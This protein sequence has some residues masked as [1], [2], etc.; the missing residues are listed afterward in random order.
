MESENTFSSEMHQDNAPLAQPDNTAREIVNMRIIGNDGDNY[1]LV[2]LHGTIVSFQCNPGYIPCGFKNYTTLLVVLA[3]NPVIDRSEIGIADINSVTK[4]GEYSP[5]YV[6][7]DLNFDLDHMVEVRGIRETLNEF[8]IYF[9]DNKNRMKTFNVLD[10]R[11]FPNPAYAPLPATPLSIGVQYMVVQGTI[12]HNAINYGPNETDN[13]FTASSTG[14]SVPAGTAKLIEYVP[15]E[16]FSIVPKVGFEMPRLIRRIDGSLTCG[17]YYYFYRL[18]DNRSNGTGYSMPSPPVYINNAE[19][20]SLGDAHQ[21]D[22]NM[23]GGEQDVQSLWGA[24]MQIDYVDENYT[25][26]ELVFMKAIDENTFEDPVIF[27]IIDIT[28]P[29]AT[30]DHTTNVGQAIP[31]NDLILYQL[32]I[33]KNKTGDINKNTLVIG[34]FEL[35]TDPDYDISVGA[36]FTEYAIRIP[37]DE[38]EVITGD[39]PTGSAFLDTPLYGVY[40]TPLLGAPQNQP[41]GGAGFLSSWYEIEETS[42]PGTGSIILQNSLLGTFSTPFVGSQYFQWPVGYDQWALNTGGANVYP[43][44]KINLYGSEARYIR[45]ENDYFSSSG[46]LVNHYVRS[47]W[48]GETYRIGLITTDLFGNPGYVHHI[49]DIQLQPHEISNMCSTFD[50]SNSVGPDR[51]YRSILNNIVI[52]VDQIDFN[53][54]VDA[55]KESQNDPS[56]TLANLPDFFTGFSIVLCKRDKVIHAEGL[57]SPIVYSATLGPIYSICPT[58]NPSF[59]RL[60]DVQGVR[61]LNRFFLRSPDLMF[62]I[63]DVPIEFEDGDLLEILDYLDMHNPALAYR[64]SPLMVSHPTFYY[65]KQYNSVVASTDQ[66]GLKNNIEVEGSKIFYGAGEIEIFGN[67][68]SPISY[69]ARI[70]DGPNAED[71]LNIGGFFPFLSCTKNHGAVLFTKDDA[72]GSGYFGYTEI[73]QTNPAVNTQ[74]PVLV[75]YKKRKNILYGGTGELAKSKNEYFFAGHYQR[76]DATFMAYLNSNAGIVEDI[77]LAGLDCHLELWDYVY[78]YPESYSSPGGLG[79]GIIMPIQSNA[80]IR[81]REGRNFAHESA[82]VGPTHLDGVS[83][84]A[85]GGGVPFQ[86]EQLVSNR[87]Y[88][89]TNAW[90]VPLVATPYGYKPRRFYEKTFAFSLRKTDGEVRDNLRRFIP[91]NTK[92][93]D[94]QYGAITNLKTKNGYLTFLQENAFGYIPI[95]ERVTIANAVGQ[96][97]NIGTKDTIDEYQTTQTFYGSRN[98]FSLTEDETALYWYDGEKKTICKASINGETIAVTVVKGLWA[99]FRSKSY[100]LPEGDI[101]LTQIGVIAGYDDNFKEVLFTFMGIK[102]A[103]TEETV[104]F[105]L[106]INALTG[107]MRGFFSTQPGIYIKYNGDLLSSGLKYDYPVLAD[108]T[109][110]TEG[111]IVKSATNPEELYVVTADFTTTTPAVDAKLEPN[112][113]YFRSDNDVHLH[114][115]GDICNFYGLVYDSSVEFVAKSKDLKEAI[116]NSYH[117]DINGS[118]VMFTNLEARTTKQTGSDLDIETSREHAIV[119]NHIEGSL[120]LDTKGERFTSP[121]LIVKFVKDHKV[122]L[123]T[124]NNEKAELLKVNINHIKAY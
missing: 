118:D 20:V 17:T 58:P 44:I 96:P 73:H 56:L 112:C 103:L 111:T 35:Q 1:S 36:S 32:P 79:I 48:R 7:S 2:D 67:M 53:I 124:S 28:G 82:R 51:Q 98:Q 30:F 11:F 78:A 109:A 105:T 77:D 55:L 122:D 90:N 87:S 123:V 3:Y 86:P 71:F 50:N 84:S 70:S 9:W 54:I 63:N 25:K 62:G 113:A 8:I 34:N 117:A 121:F 60:F 116:F 115:V 110:Y 43:V 68:G 69:V 88:R 76:F 26:I 106:A 12:L 95:Q 80:K 39:N 14:Y 120:P 52:R 21:L 4:I 91:G 101:P 119:D 29:T 45:V 107:N 114:N 18:T 94:N 40:H 37:C 10:T 99:F 59:C 83:F 27:D 92:D 24:R 57:I 102:K 47:G 66:R 81:F 104:N 75:A 23:D 89:S 6:N 13:I 74:Y 100:G 97:I 108:S 16:A 41:T 42:P 15:V 61:T 33:L 64:G 5:I 49:G 46:M 85:S 31:P 38:T 93:L 22:A 19:L 65:S 72:S